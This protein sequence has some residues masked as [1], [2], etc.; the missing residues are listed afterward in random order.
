MRATSLA[1]SRKAVKSIQFLIARNTL[2]TL[3]KFFRELCR[4]FRAFC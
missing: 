2:K 1:T 3:G 4:E